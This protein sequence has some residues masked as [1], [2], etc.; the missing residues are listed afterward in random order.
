[1]NKENTNIVSEAGT[2]PPQSGIFS[3]CLFCSGNLGLITMVVRYM[4]VNELNKGRHK[5]IQV[6]NQISLFCGFTAIGGMMV[7]AVYPMSTVSLAHDVGAYTLFI[8]GL[9][10]ASLQTLVTYYLYPSYNGLT[11]CR[12]RLT[13]VLLC[14]ISLVTMAI[15]Y[16]VSHAEFKSGNY[17]HPRRLKQLGERGFRGLVA[18]STAEWTLALIFITFFF[19]YIREFQA[20]LFQVK[21]CPLGY[22]IDEVAIK[23]ANERQ[24]LLNEQV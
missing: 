3:I 17:N 6:I 19:T 23:Q 24:P 22:H 18:S 13:I 4:Y 16:P 10:Y 8:L 2:D 11:I 1:M 12:F 15:I 9:T 21:I 20:I 7:V 14:L 5:K